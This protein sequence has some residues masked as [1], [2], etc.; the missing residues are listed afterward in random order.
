MKQKLFEIAKFLVNREIGAYNERQVKSN[1][2]QADLECIVNDL[3]T[4]ILIRS[5]KNTYLVNAREFINIA[6]VVGAN[7]YIDVSKSKKGKRVA[8]IVLFF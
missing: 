2:G 3:K 7:Y 8:C 4:E 6:E 5:S 1:I